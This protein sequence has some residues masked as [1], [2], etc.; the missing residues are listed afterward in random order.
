M[1]LAHTTPCI[2]ERDFNDS[3]IEGCLNGQ[4]A[5]I[6]PHCIGSID[7]DIHK[8]LLDLISIDEEH[9]HTGLKFLHYLYILETGLIFDKGERS[10]DEEMNIGLF[11]VR[12]PLTGE[13]QK[14]LYDISAPGRLLDDVLQI[15]FPGMVFIRLL[16]HQR[17]EGENTGQGIIDLMGYSCGQFSKSG[18][19]ASPDE[20]ILNLLK[21]PGAFLDALFQGLGPSFNVI[22]RTL[23]LCD[24]MVKRIG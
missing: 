11:L 10:I 13:V 17:T 24:H 1:V 5:A 6:F 7:N 18:H 19:L 23:Q 3:I 12:F 4:G 20:L 16:Q 15:S 14:P 22:T 8:N 2:N 21:L 9:R